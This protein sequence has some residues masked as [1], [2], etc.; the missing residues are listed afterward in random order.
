MSLTD[1]T[2]AGQ[3]IEHYAARPGSLARSTAKETLSMPNPRQKTSYSFKKPPSGR[4]S[5]TPERL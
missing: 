2:L 5:G 4:S 3:S 1:G